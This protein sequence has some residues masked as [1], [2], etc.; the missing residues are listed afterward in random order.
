M[1][2]FEINEFCWS[3][4]VRAVLLFFVVPGFV[5]S[6]STSAARPFAQESGAANLQQ[7]YDE[8]V[9]KWRD[10]A[11]IAAVAGGKFFVADREEAT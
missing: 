11:K 8:I 10:A 4:L 1:I 9:V 3:R 6:P 5:L 2:L 7:Q